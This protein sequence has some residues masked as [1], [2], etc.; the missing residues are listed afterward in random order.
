MHMSPATAFSNPEERAQHLIQQRRMSSLNTL[1]NNPISLPG[2]QGQPAFGNMPYP[3]QQLYQQQQAQRS[4]QQW[5][6]QQQQQRDAKPFPDVKQPSPQ[7]K[8][9]RPEGIGL[10][11]TDGAD[12]VSNAR[13]Q[14]SAIM[15]Q[16]REA[17]ADTERMRHADG[18]MRR[19]VAKQMRGL[20]AGG[21]LV[22]IDE[23]Y[24]VA[25]RKGVTSTAERVIGDDHRL[26]EP[27]RSKAQRPKKVR[28]SHVDGPDDDDDDDDDAIPDE[29]AINSD[30]DDPADAV[31]DGNVGDE[32]EGDTIIC[33]YD[34]V[35]RVKN[36][37]KCVLKDGV[38]NADGKE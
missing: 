2:Q 9:E 22:P 12:E 17:K 20:E 30:L 11:G 19:Q 25:E 3:N 37:W 21:L 24:T 15:S 32:Y 8:Q 14:W 33:L 31:D 6:P 18:M 26:P 10:G 1:Q 7:I 5:S 29:N 4:Q 36:K 16:N 35:Q 27:S 28:A 38:V 23:R 13:A 34:K